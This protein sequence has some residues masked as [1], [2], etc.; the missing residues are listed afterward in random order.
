VEEYQK[1][2]DGFIAELEELPH[3]N[4]PKM[5]G[6]HFDSLLA[7]FSSHIP[8]ARVGGVIPDVSLHDH[9]RITAALA[10]PLYIYHRETDTLHRKAVQ[11]QTPDKFLL[12][13]GD[14]YGTQDFIFSSGGEQQR[15]RA[16]LLRGRS[17]AVSLYSE[18]AADAFQ[19][20]RGFVDDP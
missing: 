6:Q 14:F 10:V 20:S 9:C 19:R 7:C 3:G 12:V 17:F 18:L 8:A 2:F 4:T 1:L 13:S 11:D 16:K 15:L 5:W